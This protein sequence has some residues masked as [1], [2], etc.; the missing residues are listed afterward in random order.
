MIWLAEGDKNSKFFHRKAS[1]WCW[2]NSLSRLLDSNG[3]WQE[4]PKNIGQVV[5]QFYSHLFTSS[6]PSDVDLILRIVAHSFNSE[7]VKFLS[8]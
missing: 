4:G 5:L 1:E 6:N 2:F 3:C 8:A 7:Q